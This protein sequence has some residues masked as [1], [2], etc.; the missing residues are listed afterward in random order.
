[1]F[2]RKRL[3]EVDVLVIDEISMLENYTFERLNAVMQ[4]ARGSS[5]AFGGVQLVVTGDFC[6][7]PPVKP[8]GTCITCGREMRPL[9]APPR[10]K[11]PQHGE[12]LEIEKWAFRSAAWKLAQFEH[13]NLT[14]IHRQR[15]RTFIDIL[16]KLRMGKQLASKDTD[17]LLNHECNVE[18]PVKLYSTREEV[19]RINNEA[20]AKLPSEKRVFRCWDN[21]QHNEKHRNLVQKGERL[22]DGSLAALREHKLE[23]YIELK[24]GM[25]II[26]LRNLSIEEGLVNGSQGVIIGWE[27]Y[28]K[29]RMPTTSDR[30]QKN[31]DRLR[32]IVDKA[33]DKQGSSKASSADV[34]VGEHAGLREA[35]IKAFIH[36]ASNKEWPIV[37]FDNGVTRT[38]F[39]D[40]V[41]NELGDEVPYSLLSRT[42]IPLLAGWAM[43]VHKSQ[44]MTLNKVV[45]DLSRSFEEGQMYVAL[46]RAR[47]LHGLR[48]DG[49][50]RSRADGGNAQVMEFLWEKFRVR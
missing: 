19:R 8:F 43:T 23:P 49:L 47:A 35:N 21:F 50:G 1:V 38:I 36:Q 7:L 12:I 2:V 39:A 32:Q 10:F 37:K 26:L 42:Q 44:G 46:S 25:L 3:R 20:F 16:E 4:E 15:D 6:Q 48:V 28:D 17:L 29:D 11:C 45:V 34:I 5:K 13:V 22:H 24:E 41:I 30:K 31:A 18:N 40:C 33:G 27:P 14:T 9:M